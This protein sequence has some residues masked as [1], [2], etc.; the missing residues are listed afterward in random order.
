MALK[1]HL[2]AGE[3]AR[4]LGV[5]AATLY[6][7][8]SRGH[9]RSEP[10]ADAR[11]SRLYRREDIELLKS[12]KEARR[13]PLAAAERNLSWGLPVLE[14]ALT[15]I[16]NGRLYYRGLDAI[17]LAATRTVEE[18]ASL[19]WEGE[20][21]PDYPRMLAQA[22][23]RLT[24]SSASRH[25]LPDL[26]P[27]ER[28]RAVLA[29]AES[30]DLNAY[31]FDHAALIETGARIVA[32]LVLAA[33][34]RIKW[35][36]RIAHTLQSAWAPSDPAA[37]PVLRAALILLVDH[38]LAVS[39]FSAR[40]VASAA[41]PLYAVV[42]A[43]L[44]ALRGMKHGGATERAEELLREA[45]TPRNVRNVI[46]GRLRRGEQIPG[47]GHQLYPQG[48]PR[49][50]FLLEMLARNYAGSPAIAL[51]RSIMKEASRISDRMLPNI[52]FAG[53][54]LAQALHLPPGSAISIFALGR[55]IGWIGHAIEQYRIDRLIRP[56]ARYIGPPPSISSAAAARQKTP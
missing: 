55:T 14:S 36:N 3:A 1:E 6:A 42:E 11:R 56:R 19:M 46:A 35:Q 51:A 17:E 50:R 29:L 34:P 22:A 37:E 54:V 27:L 20:F 43:G 28:F 44:C 4:E 26:P 30:G 52:D 2:T 33:A 48:D 10:S 40:C 45:A 53:A 21:R 18:V 13:N 24:G 5:S 9:I 16:S 38:E 31:N 25:K 39:S 32:M 41:S 7:Y 15:L 8:V 23:A 12:R 47:F 49:A